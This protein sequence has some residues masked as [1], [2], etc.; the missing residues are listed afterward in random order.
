[1]TGA[2]YHS[3]LA[4]SWVFMF[5]MGGSSVQAELPHVL[6]IRSLQGPQEA[7]QALSTGGD[8][9]HPASSGSGFSTCDCVMLSP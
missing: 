2:D 5:G 4:W 7:G 1:M 9:A 3:T 6:L 8:S